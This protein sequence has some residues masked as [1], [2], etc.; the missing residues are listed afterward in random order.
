MTEK[1][2][3]VLSKLTREESDKLTSRIIATME[4]TK[5]FRKS[6]IISKCYCNPLETPRYSQKAARY[7]VEAVIDLFLKTG[8]LVK[9][10]KV[11]RIAMDGKEMKEDGKKA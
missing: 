1:G 2:K 7:G 8:M 9:D 3:T 11:Y 10:G 4:T 5:K 6:E